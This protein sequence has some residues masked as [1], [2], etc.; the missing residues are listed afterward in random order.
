VLDDDIWECLLGYIKDRVRHLERLLGRVERGGWREGELVGTRRRGRERRLRRVVVPGE[1]GDGHGAIAREG[2]TLPGR[3]TEE[4]ATQAEPRSKGVR[5]ECWV[6]G[7][8]KIVQGRRE[9]W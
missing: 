3:E 7:R 6:F 5:R 8:G 1:R 9:I 4:L 2:A